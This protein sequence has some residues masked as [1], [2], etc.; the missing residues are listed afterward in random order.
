ML[1]LYRLMPILAWTGNNAST[2]ASMQIPGTRTF[3]MQCAGEMLTR[4]DAAIRAVLPQSAR[5]VDPRVPASPSRKPP[6]LS[7]RQG[8]CMHSCMKC[9]Q[10]CVLLRDTPT[11]M[12]S[13]GVRRVCAAK[14]IYSRSFD[15]PS[16]PTGAFFVLRPKGAMCVRL[17]RLGTW[18][19]SRNV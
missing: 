7:G 12:E 2:T 17:I 15:F 19:R 9:L 14:W 10:E 5:G 4:K 1:N 8:L 13:W 16:D 18:R 6:E 3:T 11:G